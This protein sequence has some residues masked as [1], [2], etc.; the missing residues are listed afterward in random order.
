M[1]ETFSVSTSPEKEISE[2]IDFANSFHTISRTRCH[3]KKKIVFPDT[4][5]FKRPRFADNKTLDVRTNYRPTETFQYTH[6]SSSNPPTVKKGFIKGD[7]LRLLRTTSVKET[8]ELRNLKFLTRLLE[9]GYP[10]E[11]DQNILA[12]VKL[13]SRKNEALQSKANKQ[14]PK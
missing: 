9:Q 3:Q 13:S 14:P 4:K 6:F 11:L 5:V 12:E 7:T 2:F 10:R 1:E 8:F